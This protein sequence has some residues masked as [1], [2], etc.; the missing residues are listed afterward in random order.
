MFGRRKKDDTVKAPDGRMSSLD[1]NWL[2]QP[3][4]EASRAPARAARRRPA[5]GGASDACAGPVE[6]RLR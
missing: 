5:T 6:V 2:D 4:A 3:V 1:P